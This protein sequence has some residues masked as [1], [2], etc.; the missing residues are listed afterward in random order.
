MGAVVIGLAASTAVAS[1]ATA[2]PSGPS[3]RPAAA[4]GA[5]PEPDVISVDF[6]E[7][8][9][10]EHAADRALTAEGVA[11]EV[12]YDESLQ[13]HVAEFAADEAKP[14]T[15]TGAYVADIPDAW[16]ADDPAHEDEVDLLDGGTFEC[17]F[18]YDGESPVPSGQASQLCGGGPEGYAFYLPATGS[19]LRFKATATSGNKNTATAPIAL[20]SGEWVHAVV[21]VGG[22]DIKMYLNGAPA[23]NLEQEDGNGLGSGRNHNGPY[24]ELKVDSVPK[25]GIGGAPTADGFSQPANTAVA[26]SRAWSAVLTDAEVADLWRQEKPTPPDV[27]L[28][29]ADVLDVD[30]SDEAEPFR[31]HS[32]SAR[33]PKV[34]GMSDVRTDPAFATQPHRAYTADGQK[35][36]AF[37]PLQD[38]WADTGEPHSDDVATYVDDTWAGEGA[39]LQCDVKVNEELPVDG[40]PHLCSGKSGGGFGL[41][42]KGSSIVAGFHV[43]GGYKSVTSPEIRSGVWHSVVATF[44]GTRVDLYLDGERVGS[45]TTDTVGPIA[46]PTSG[47]IIEPYVRYYA[48]GSDVAGRGSI[49]HPAEVTVGNARIWSSALSAE[50]AAQL[51]RESF[52]DRAVAPELQSSVPAA[53]SVVDGPTEFGVTI[54]E[55]SLATG[56]TYALDGEP[57]APGDVIGAGMT[58]GDHEIVV[59]ATDV[60]GRPVSWSIPFTSPRIPTAGGT[61]TQ[62]KKGA[63]RLTAI[64]KSESENVTTTFTE[65]ELTGPSAGVQ[66]TIDASPENLGLDFAADVDDVT[67]ITDELAP[68]DDEA[69]TSPAA[70]DGFPFQRFDVDLPNADPGQQVLWSGGVDPARVVKL[71]VW[72]AD[73][74]AWALVAKARGEAEG[75]TRLEGALHPRL[76]DADDPERLAAHVLVTAE[77]PFADDLAPRDESAGTPEAKDHFEDPDDY[78][79]SFVHYTDQQYTTEAATGSDMDWPASLPWQHIDGATNTPEEAAVFEKSLRAQN[80]WIA[81]NADERRIDYVAN[82]GDLINSDVSLNDLQFDPDA[83]DPGDGSSVFDYTTS[84]GSVPGSKEQ[85]AKE[86]STMLDLQEPLWGSGVPN[87]TIAGNHDNHNG[88]HN[89]PT[90]PFAAFFTAGDYYD[91]AENAWPADASFHT[92]DEVSDPDSGKIVTEG[93]DSSNSYVLFSAGGLDFVAVGLSYGVTQEESD[94]ADSVFKRYPDRNGILMTHGYLGA[95]AEPDGRDAALGAD[96]SKLYD[97]VVRDNTNVFLVLGGHFHG[98]GTNVET[99]EGPGMNHKVVQMLADYQGYMVPAGTV[100]TKERCASA[101]LDPSTQCVFGTGEDEGKI[102]VDGDGSWD[103]LTSDK[104]AMGA[105][106]LRML[107]FD[108]EQNTMSVDTYSPFLDEFG[109]S[110]Y[111]HGNSPKET[112]DP[113]E[114]YNGAEDNLTLPIDLTTRQTSFTT[115]ALTVATPT[116]E[117]IGSRTVASG[118]PATVAWKGLTEGEAYAWTAS[119]T[120]E[121]AESGVVTQFGDLFVATAAGTDTTAPVLTIPES[122]TIAEGSAF[123]PLEGVTAI[124]DTDGDVSDRIEVIGEVDTSVTGPHVLVYRVTDTNGNQA[125]GPRLVIV[126]AAAGGPGDPEE[127]GDPGGPG[128]PGDPGDD[129]GSGGSGGSD[130]A[131]GS[132]GSDGAGGAGDPGPAAGDS[133]QGGEGFLPATGAEISATVIAAGLLLLGAG[134]VLALAARRRPILR[135]HAR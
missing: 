127:P 123:D 49:E 63:A 48:I 2:A 40:T 46:A 37:Y 91:Q 88:T 20:R 34:T 23:W 90:S 58:A 121:G 86:F 93:E 87:Q 109:A 7:D 73:E 70:H 115:D 112:P 17:Y 13:R 12:V 92:M 67:E 3:T 11:P 128:D 38:T 64:V 101:G 14:S 82:T 107:Q 18:R 132:G 77:D 71:W 29:E 134:A 21:T 102:D 95:S 6:T 122:T 10:V 52:G 120:E 9:P 103:H 131:G 57:I 83:V 104:L 119:S 61:D 53:G 54:S 96:G 56:W 35:D 44:D 33:E 125:I 80:E 94:W 79:F 45:N 78:D 135:G 113:I 75:D 8:G 36:H 117:V 72:D 26:A 89:G 51:D 31:D 126:E 68:G 43:N 76:I 27:E 60:F 59:S 69:A 133:G 62:Q 1:P 100:F 98:V 4:E 84:D 39:T 118:M 24:T 42:L 129:G 74:G 108:T 106:F 30:F 41:H 110:G 116:D 50:Q 22:G 111:D 81:D 5:V 85:I 47:S 66:G 130:G 25:W 28:P 65:A 105:S 15:G 32:P 97:E 124:D 19:G 16:S 99:I 55:P 114:R